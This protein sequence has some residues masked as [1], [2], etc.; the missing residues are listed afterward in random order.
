MDNTIATHTHKKH[1]H[2][3][4]YTAELRRASCKE[5]TRHINFKQHTNI[6]HFLALY[7]MSTSLCHGLPLVLI[8]YLIEQN[9]AV[10]FDTEN[11][12]ILLSR[13]SSL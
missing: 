11:I 7:V 2:S 8:A 4:G 10:M 13:L 12:L 5:Y 9:I 6:L 3:Y 1:T